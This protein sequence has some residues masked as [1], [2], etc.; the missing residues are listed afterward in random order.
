MKSTNKNI[1]L[2]IFLCLILFL[3]TACNQDA[4]G[5]DDLIQ[6]LE[7]LEERHNQLIIEYND[8]ANLYESL[9]EAHNQ[10]ISETVELDQLTDLEKDLVLNIDNDALLITISLQELLLEPEKYDGKFVKISTN[11]RPMSNRVERKSF[12]TL[13]KTGPQ[14]WDVD[15]SFTLEVFYSEMENW[16][17]LGSM[18]LDKDATIRVEGTFH[19]YGNKYSRGYLKASKITFIN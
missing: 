17:E 6:R 7:S 19:I 5:N 4:G 18:T 9:E 10:L 14:S 12:S 16:K 11:L 8:L 2:A 1:K 13:L 15:S 3:S